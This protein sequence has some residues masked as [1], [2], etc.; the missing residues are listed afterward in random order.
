MAPIGRPTR[1]VDP[2]L[3]DDFLVPT[4]SFGEAIYIFTT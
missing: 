3:M 4:H 2:L 1:D